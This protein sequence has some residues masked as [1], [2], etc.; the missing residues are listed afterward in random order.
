LNINNKTGWLLLKKVI[1]LH[2]PER[3][4]THAPLTDPTVWGL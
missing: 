2:P 1:N 3:N 4:L